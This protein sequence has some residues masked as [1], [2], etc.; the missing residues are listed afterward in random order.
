MATMTSANSTLRTTNALWTLIEPQ[1][2]DVK[3]RLAKLINKSIEESESTE[4]TTKQEVISHLEQ[5]CKEAK[6]IREG[7]LQAVT[8]EELMNGL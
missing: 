6:L 7:K 1:G 5:A 4:L 3:I 8:V 2:R